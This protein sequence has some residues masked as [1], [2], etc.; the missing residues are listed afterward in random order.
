MVLLRVRVQEELAD[1]GCT[2]VEHRPQH[3]D[4]Q[5]RRHGLPA[6]C[7]GLA[8]NLIVDVRRFFF[9]FCAYMNIQVLTM[10]YS[11]S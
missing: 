5:G 9:F 6:S 3:R 11:S 8:A 10:L 7:Q 1:M 4:N 2:Q